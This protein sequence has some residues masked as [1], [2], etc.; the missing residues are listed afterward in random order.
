MLDDIGFE[1][2][3][4]LKNIIIKKEIVDRQ[5]HGADKTGESTIEGIHFVLNSGDNLFVYCTDWS[6]K[7]DYI[8]NLKVQ[9]RKFEYIE[10]L[11]KIQS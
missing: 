5:K 1:I 3:D 2:S 4:I 9:I 10:Y 11:K 6:D 8:D 7:L